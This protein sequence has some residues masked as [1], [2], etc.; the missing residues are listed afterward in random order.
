MA[1]RCP[2]IEFPLIMKI[3]LK[4]ISLSNSNNSEENREDEANGNYRS[5]FYRGPLLSKYSCSYFETAL[6]SRGVTLISFITGWLWAVFHAVPMIIQLC[7]PFTRIAR[8][9]SREN[10]YRILG[11][12]NTGPQKPTTRAIPTPM[13]N[14]CVSRKNLLRG[15]FKS[16]Q[17]PDLYNGCSPKTSFFIFFTNFVTL[18]LK[19]DCKKNSII[20]PEKK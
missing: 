14:E 10:E 7:P 4:L 8:N 16:I 5:C 12:G 18:F 17:R 11:S 20:D 13:D 1:R 9:G 3:N 19:R 15:S 2:F 6:Q